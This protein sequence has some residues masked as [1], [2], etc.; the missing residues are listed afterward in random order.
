MRRAAVRPPG[1]PGRS[2]RI[3]AKCKRRKG[4]VFSKRFHGFVAVTRGASRGSAFPWHAGSAARVILVRCSSFLAALVF[5][6][7]RPRTGSAPVVRFVLGM[8]AMIGALI[9]LGC[10]WRAMLRLA[11]GD[12]NAILGLIGLVIG[13]TIG[14]G[15]LRAGFSLGRSH[16]ARAP[17]GLVMPMLMIGLLMLAVFYPRFGDGAALFRS[18]SIADS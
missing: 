4:F 11:G 1:H 9:F 12:W 15:F 16:P 6:E 5:R 13:I 14:V 17:V 8:F 3:D 7:F 18:A 10:P 2:V